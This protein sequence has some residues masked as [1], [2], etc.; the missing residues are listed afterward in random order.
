MN[1]ARSLVLNSKLNSTLK[2]YIGKLNQAKAKD[3]KLSSDL[4]AM[5][6]TN[7]KLGSKNEALQSKLGILVSN[8]VVLKIKIDVTVE[9][10]RQAKIRAL[11]AQGA[12]RQAKKRA[13]VAEQTIASFNQNFDAMVLEKD[14][15][16]AKERDST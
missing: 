9:D 16:L 14:K 12:R 5:G 11:E 1:T 7:N 13:T 8:E 2:G 3:K 10:V 4:R 15:Q 6:S